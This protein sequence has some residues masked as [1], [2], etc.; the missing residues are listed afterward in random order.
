MLHD[1]P[2]DPLTPPMI[3]NRIC[4]EHFGRALSLYVTAPQRRL[5]HHSGQARRNVAG[6][7]LWQQGRQLGSGFGEIGLQPNGFAKRLDRILAASHRVIC[8][9]KVHPG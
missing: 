3:V 5:P 6:L 4:Q 1:T 8:H 2:A 9:A 7:S